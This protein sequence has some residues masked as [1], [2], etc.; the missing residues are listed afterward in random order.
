MS[1][2]PSPIQIKRARFRAL[3]LGECFVTPN[4]WD[5]GSA[6]YLEHLG[7][8]A[9]ATTSGGFAFSQGLPDSEGAVSR[10]RSLLHI[11]QIAAAVDVPVHADFCSGYGALPEQ[12]AE[13]VAR[14]V[15]TGIAGLSIEDGTG[16]RARPLFDLPTSVARVRAAREALDRS[17]AGVLLTARAECYR[18]GHPDALRESARRL[19]AY[20]EAGADVLF[21]PGVRAPEQI[22][23]LVAAVRPKPL[24]VLVSGNVGLHVDE[25]AA[26]GVR[27]VSVGCALA[28]AAWNAMIRAAQT[29]RHAG[30]FA[31]FETGTSFAW[32][33]ELF[34]A[35]LHTRLETRAHRTERE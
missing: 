7:F 31:A 10:E 12:V 2:S 4:P 30:S 28:L 3:H 27:R 15:E 14:C 33:N 8:P 19:A 20:A 9:L 5:L 29:L 11:A 26:L 22:H 1:Q 16:D 25:L 34:S 17:G 32:I 24:H 21:A 6:R 35:D 23:A 18:V 13:S